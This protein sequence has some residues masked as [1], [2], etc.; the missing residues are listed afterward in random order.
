MV[1]SAIAQEEEDDISSSDD[2]NLASSILSNGLDGSSG[3]NDD[4]NDDS[5]TGEEDEDGDDGDSNT[6]IAVPITDQ[7]QRDANLAE[8]LGLNADILEE[9]E[10]IPTPTPEEVDTTPPILTVPEDI[11]AEPIST[12]GAVVT[13]RVTAQDNVDGTATLNERNV[14]TQDG[15][16]GDITISCDPPSGTTFPIGETD[17]ECTA[18]DE[19]GN[20]GTASFTITVAFTCQ[21]EIATIVGTPG[22]DDLPGTGA[23]DV[24]ALLEGDDRVFAG[25]GDDLICGDEGNDPLLV[26]DAGDDEVFGG[27]GNDVMFGG[28]DNDR[29]SGGG[30]NDRMSG[31]GGNDNLNSVDGVMN[32]DLL[33]GDTGTDTCTSDPDPEINCEF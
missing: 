24:I 23:R 14:L 3:D 27:E 31:G 12:A 2:E 20:I 19:A 10:V 26:G 13:F 9:E 6:Q 1:P 7:D 18:T 16:G 5:S 21:G 4:E 8:Q 22:N 30:G 11:V 28:S 32:N 29:M 17:V 15:V 33:N 25:G